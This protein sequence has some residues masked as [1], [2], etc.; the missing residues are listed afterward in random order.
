[1]FRRQERC[2]PRSQGAT[3]KQDHAFW[4]LDSIGWDEGIVWHSQGTNIVEYAVNNGGV[5]PEF[6]GVEPIYGTIWCAGVERAR[7]LVALWVGTPS[8]I[9]IEIDKRFGLE[10][11]RNES[12]IFFWWQHHCLASLR[13]RAL[14]WTPFFLHSK[15]Q[16]CPRSR[17]AN[18]LS[19]RAQNPPS[20]DLHARAE[21]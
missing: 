20:C 14:L 5:Q 21:R 1:M 12:F 9:V 7:A 10:S 11:P 16:L 19:L 3:K 15:A 8:Q 2:R 13:L 17:D 4:L 18:N 6:S